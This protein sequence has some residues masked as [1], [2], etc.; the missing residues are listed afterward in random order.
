[1]NSLSK[2]K[3]GNIANASTYLLFPASL[4]FANTT[5]F[6]RKEC[7]VKLLNIVKLSLSRQI[8]H[9]LFVSIRHDISQIF[10][11]IGT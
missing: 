3:Q 11:T 2:L 8:P 5:I 1:M 10:F 4:Y 6:A 7:S 9:T